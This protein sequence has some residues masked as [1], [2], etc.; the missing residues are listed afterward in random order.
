MAELTLNADLSAPA[1]VDYIIPAQKQTSL[2]GT[3][4]RLLMENDLDVASLR[5]WVSRRTNK[6]Y[7]TRNILGPDGKPA[8]KHV[9]VNNDTTLYDLDW[10]VIDSAVQR[11][12]KPRLKA[13]ADL[14]RRNLTY[15]LPGGIGKTMMTFR[16]MSDIT[17][18]TVS[19]DGLRE[20]ERD[21]PTFSTYNMPIPLIHKDFSYSLRE[22]LASRQGNT[23]LDTATA[24]LAASRVA[25]QVE[26]LLLGSDNTLFDGQSSFTWNQASVLGYLNSP[27]RITYSLTLPTTAGWTP[28]DLINTILGMKQAAQAARYYGPF[29]LY[30]GSYWDLYMD[31][32]YSSAKGDN[33]L[34]QRIRDID[35][36]ED[37]E[38]L[39]YIGDSALLLVQMS[40]D[41]VRLVI[42]LDIT[43]VRWESHGGFQENF[44][45]LCCIVP[46]VRGNSSGSTG[47][48]HASAA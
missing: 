5:P 26:Q 41:V 8:R 16:R 24:E 7:I 39:D 9:Q 2:A 40:S 33:T 28:A 27:E 25:E 4:A 18:A 45:V 23:P 47:I 48:V 12:V 43:T 14:R 10:K 19:M 3:H 20:S 46:Q 15:N 11:A 1:S 44:K 32:D 35:G 22:L 36:I 37:V 17:G 34:R 38:T 42:G 31:D 13:V 6:T 29:V 21:R 30:C